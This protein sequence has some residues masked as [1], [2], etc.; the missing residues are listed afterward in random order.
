MDVFSISVHTLIPHTQINYVSKFSH[1][2]AKQA[3]AVVIA[4]TIVAAIK[5]A[6]DF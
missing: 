3:R 2:R 4:A 6:G 5:D 1:C